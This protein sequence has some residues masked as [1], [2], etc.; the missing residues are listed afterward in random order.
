MK[1][2]P[3][4]LLRIFIR[5]IRHCTILFFFISRDGE[6]LSPDG[7][8]GNLAFHTRL[9]PP[10][11]PYVLADAVRIREVLVNI[12]GNAEI[13]MVQLEEVGIQ[14]TRA[15]D[16]MEAVRIITENPSDTFDMIFMDV[17]MPE[18]N[19]YEATKAIRSIPNRPDAQQIPIIAMTANVSFHL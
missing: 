18:M 17:M 13:A 9:M 19:G 4:T 2:A 14:V 15:V 6:D 16:G 5:R 1:R 7:Q 12:L 10:A 3:L 8:R 11:E